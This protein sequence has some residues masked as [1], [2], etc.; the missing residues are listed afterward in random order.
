MS[1]VHISKHSPFFSI[2]L[3]LSRSCRLSDVWCGVC[4]VLCFVC[5]HVACPSDSTRQCCQLE[6]LVLALSGLRCQRSSFCEG[7]ALSGM[8]PRL[9]GWAS[10]SESDLDSNASCCLGLKD[11]PCDC[12]LDQNTHASCN[13]RA[14]SLSSAVSQQNRQRA[15]TG[16]E[17]ERN[18]HVSRAGCARAV[19]INPRRWPFM[20]MTAQ[21]PTSD[22]SLVDVSI[23]SVFAENSPN[24]RAHLQDLVRGRH[25]TTTER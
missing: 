6:D 23:R 17:K 4:G 24:A 19:W 18:L 16:L 11:A 5:V 15:G 7:E 12:P 10:F 3:A 2:A 9:S 22:C 1:L 13:V 25:A 21:W 20:D 14:R 8:W